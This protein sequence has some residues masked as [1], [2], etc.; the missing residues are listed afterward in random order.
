MTL[1][2]AV[3]EIGPKAMDLL[4]G[5][6]DSTFSQELANRLRRSIPPEILSDPDP[7]SPPVPDPQTMLVAQEVQNNQVANEL[8]AKELE[9]KAFVESSKLEI[10]REAQELKEFKAIMEAKNTE[11]DKILQLKALIDRSQERSSDGLRT[12]ET[13]ETQETQTETEKRI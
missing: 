3:P 10:Q 8:K 5:N 1:V 6:I 4:V 13:Q 2:Q 12:Q 9:L 7:N 11:A